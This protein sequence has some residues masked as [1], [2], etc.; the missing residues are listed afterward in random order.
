M[1]GALARGRRAAIIPP[2]IPTLS[3][4]GVGELLPLGIGDV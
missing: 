4:E 3:V 2:F 1:F